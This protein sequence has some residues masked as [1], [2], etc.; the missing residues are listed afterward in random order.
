MSWERVWEKKLDTKVQDLLSTEGVDTVAQMIK[1]VLK[2]RLDVPEDGWLTDEKIIK[3][4]YKQPRETL[5]QHGFFWR[6]RYRSRQN[7]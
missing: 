4:L 1:W 5:L 7:R 3:R 2:E 6:A